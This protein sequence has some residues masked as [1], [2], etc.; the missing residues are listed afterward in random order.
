M[1]AT[2]HA[3]RHGIGE[4]FHKRLLKAYWED[5][6][7]LEDRAV[8]REA[9]EGAGLSWPDMERSLDEGTYAEAVEEQM[10]VAQQSG[11][12]GIPAYV[13]ADKYL[14]MGAQPY[15]LFKQVVDRVIEERSAGG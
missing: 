10:E 14:V 5:G 6:R 1:E 13:I 9:A 7:D 2:E 4:P 8:L 11:I 12:T 15:T 3:K